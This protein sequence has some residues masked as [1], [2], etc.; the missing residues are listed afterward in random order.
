MKVPSETGKEISSEEVAADKQESMHLQEV[1][2]DGRCWWK[3]KTK[4]R[5]WRELQL[6]IL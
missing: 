2:K 4:R 6:R 5:S 3:A 1:E